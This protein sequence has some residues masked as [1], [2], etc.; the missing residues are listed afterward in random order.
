MGLL[1]LFA[2]SVLACAVPDL[3]PAALGLSRHAPDLFTAVAVYLGLVGRGYGA[4]TGA[5]LLGLLQDCASLDPLGSHAFVLGIVALVFLRPGR[6]T[7]I[8][9]A[10]R[11]TCVVLG[12]V[13]GRLLLVV[14]MLAVMKEGRPGLGFVADGVLSALWTALASWP[15]FALLDRTHALEDFTGGTRGVSA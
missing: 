7:P 10:S 2:L 15:L 12:C 3:T 14:R 13:F 8:R 4:L 1:V 11:A 9:G 5:V 6:S